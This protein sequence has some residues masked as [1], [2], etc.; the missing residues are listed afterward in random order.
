M[1]KY[2][3]AKQESNALSQDNESQI[4]LQNMYAELELAK[5]TNIDFQNKLF[6]SMSEY[7]VLKDELIL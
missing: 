2:N 7:D 6:D 5:S 1:N 3:E 4:K